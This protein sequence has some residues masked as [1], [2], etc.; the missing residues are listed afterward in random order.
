[1]IEALKHTDYNKEDNK[2][3]PRLSLLGGISTRDTGP[4]WISFDKVDFGTDGADTIHIPIFSFDEEL[5]F[6]IWEGNPYAEGSKCLVKATYKA[7][8]TYNTYT[9][10]VY[11]LPKRLFGVHK[12]GFAFTTGLYFQGFYFDQTKKALSKLRALDA[13][14]V[15]G[16][17]FTK[18]EKAVEQIGNNVNLD[19]ENMDFGEEGATKITICGKSNTENNSI[20][21]KFFDKDGNSTTQLIEFAHTDSYQEKTFDLEKIAGK[22]KISFVFLPGCNFDFEWFKFW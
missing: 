12:L 3:K 9:E 19:F 17:S 8:S 6:E 20:N 21:I 18:T 11:T 4:T 15:A 22:G 10:N 1:M 14:V 13:N 16:D 2:P 5:P 7:P